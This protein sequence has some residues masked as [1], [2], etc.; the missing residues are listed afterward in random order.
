M[1]VVLDV[2]VRTGSDYS[3]Q[4]NV[5]SAT[6]AAQV[7]GSMITLWGEPGDP[8]H[9]S[10]RGWA[11]IAAGAWLLEGQ[12][13]EPPEPRSST[14]FLRLPTSCE[15]PLTATL[16]G[17]SWSGDVLEGSA[18]IPAL[19]GC[20]ELSFSPSL[21]IAPEVHS[22]STPTGLSVSLQMPQEALLAPDGLAQ[23]D[24]RD[25]TIALPEG[26]QLSPSAA[27]GLQ[28]CS[29]QQIGFSGLNRADPD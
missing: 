5:S 3:V 7:L 28:A 19:T 22:A 29:E 15:G 14:P 10:S 27:N 6:S 4:V 13:C 23:A 16:T 1:P 17:S 8:R 2:S 11:C 20:A 24:L 21:G 18:S 25:A 26:V 9:D 12:S